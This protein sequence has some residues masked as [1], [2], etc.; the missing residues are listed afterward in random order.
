MNNFYIAMSEKQTQKH[1][2]E[3]YG[4]TCP[5]CHGIAPIVDK[6]EKEGI[7]VFDRLEV[8]NNTENKARMESLKHH[9]DA[10]CNGNMIVPSFYDA[11]TDRLICNPGTYERLK[12]WIA[13]TEK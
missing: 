9:Y 5:F 10:N 1:I 2:I 8:W 6:L 11:S 7:A 13:D 4:D 12:E 3:F